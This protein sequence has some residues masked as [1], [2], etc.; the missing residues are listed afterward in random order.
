MELVDSFSESWTHKKFTSVRLFE[1]RLFES[2][3]TEKIYC[4]A[5]N[6][7]LSNVNA[8]SYIIQDVR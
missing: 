2:K 6:A 1:K 5:Y 4:D 7:S 8:P 3:V